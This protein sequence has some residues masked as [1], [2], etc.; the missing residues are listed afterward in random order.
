MQE[1]AVNRR[2][3]PGTVRRRRHHARMDLLRDPF[4]TC[5]VGALP[6]ALIL[7]W[8]TRHRG[9]AGA[10]PAAAMI[11]LAQ[12]GAFLMLGHLYF[13]ISAP[14]RAAPGEWVY[15]FRFYG[16]VLFGVIV[17]ATCST[18]VVSAV[19]MA[20]RRAGAARHAACAALVVL[21]LTLPL[22]PLQPLAWGMSIG[23]GLALVVAWLG[24]RA[25]PA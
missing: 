15:E 9:P 25:D 24:G 5:C 3:V 23:A 13:V 14:L 10:L 18:G 21:V 8:R 4:V 12:A 2:F 1:R 6:V 20:R 17:L 11:L 22:I 19:R 7:V 16:M